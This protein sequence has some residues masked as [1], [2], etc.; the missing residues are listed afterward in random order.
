MSISKLVMSF[1][2]ADGSTTTFSYNYAK[3]SAST[4]A[5]KALAGGLVTSGD[6]FANVPVLAKSAKFITS[7]ETEVDLDA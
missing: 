5:V 3:P 1:A 4:A 6:I 7:T 2:T